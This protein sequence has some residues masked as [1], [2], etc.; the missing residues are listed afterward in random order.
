MN[1]SA[2]T[3]HAR[4]QKDKALKQNLEEI[5]RRIEQIVSKV[6]EKPAVPDDVKIL[7]K[8]IE[9]ECLGMRVYLREF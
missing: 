8:D 1:E 9:D 5:S 4:I 7:L 2:W 6:Q 3:L